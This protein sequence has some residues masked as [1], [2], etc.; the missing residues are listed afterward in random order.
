MH[1]QFKCSQNLHI[2]P[3]FGVAFISTINQKKNIGAF[4]IIQEKFFH[5]FGKMGYSGEMLV[6]Y[7]KYAL[8]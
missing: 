2:N 1:I 6:A 8:D 7:N 5:Q 3:H 4:I